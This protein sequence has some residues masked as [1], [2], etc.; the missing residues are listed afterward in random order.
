M[1]KFF[2]AL[3]ILLALVAVGLFSLRQFSGWNDGMSNARSEIHAAVLGQKLYVA[4]GIGLFRVLDSC[5][6][7]DLTTR[8]WD[9]CETLPRPL[10]HVAMAADNKRVYASGGYVALPFE[11]DQDAA[12]IALDPESN[13][14]NEV[15]KLPH[16]VGQHAMVYR[17]GKLYLIGGQNGFEDLAT[18]WSYD[19][20]LNQW[21]EMASMPTPHHSHAIAIEG[22]KLYVTGGR[23][24]ALGTEITIVEAYDFATGRW[25][26]LPEMPTRR[27]GHGAFI[28]AGNLLAKAS[29]FPDM[30]YS[31]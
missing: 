20:E 15:S 10:H 11:Q 28:R 27:A 29:C 22:S 18:L 31:I 9:A 19:L 3:L 24:A 6:V 30:I 5:E 25:D 13:G 26:T 16:P 7:F 4:G 8:E 2:T 14:W 12:L 23:S 1:K 21:N 17:H